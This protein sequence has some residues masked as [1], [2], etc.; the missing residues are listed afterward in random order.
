MSVE[1]LFADFYEQI[2]GAAL[3]A[4]ALAAFVEVVNDLQ[5]IEQEVVA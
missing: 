1:A 2:T 3:S 4:D 5:H